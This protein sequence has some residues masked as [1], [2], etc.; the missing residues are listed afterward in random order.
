MNS[1]MVNIKG[2]A[3]LLADI[4]PC[5]IRKAIKL[6]QLEPGVHFFTIAD[7]EPI[8]EWNPELRKKL[9]ESCRKKPEARKQRPQTTNEAKINYGSLGLAHLDTSKPISEA[10]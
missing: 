9:F 5:H 7:S 10:P 2:L 3:K 4:D 1:E 6:G 8:F